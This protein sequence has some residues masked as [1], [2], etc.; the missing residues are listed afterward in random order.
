MLRSL[1]LAVLT[2]CTM[3]VQSL[4]A[5]ELAKANPLPA[6]T[7]ASGQDLYMVCAFYPKP[8]TCEAIY[9]RAMKD[10]SITAEAV[11]AEY[12]GYARYLN[13]AASL[14][15]ADRQ[16]L[17]DNGIM[18]PTD[19]SAVNQAGLHRVINDPSLTPDVKRGAVN[20]FLSRAVEAELYCGFNDCKSADVE[21]AKTGV[22]GTT[23]SQ[24]RSS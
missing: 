23:A 15:D 3:S 12:T 7:S 19:L 21:T 9:Q 14:T 20:N 16:Y 8:G 6:G 1:S 17:Q 10:T 2:A 5:E 18:V 24:N 13:G 4:E 11:R 22:G